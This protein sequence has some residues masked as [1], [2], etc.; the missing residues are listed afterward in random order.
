MFIIHDTGMRFAYYNTEM[1]RHVCLH[2][3][4]CAYCMFEMRRRVYLHDKSCAYE[5]PP[6]SKVY[7]NRFVITKAPSCHMEY[8]E[9]RRS[10][11][12]EASLELSQRNL[13][14]AQ[15]HRS[16]S[17]V[18][19]NVHLNLEAPSERL[20]FQDHSTHSNA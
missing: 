17:T 14:T 2:D 7:Q 16:K 4:S 10:Y 15:D 6:K 12:R 18:C 3:K 8:L 19:V 9:R 13:P 5:T 20:T 1:R 11:W